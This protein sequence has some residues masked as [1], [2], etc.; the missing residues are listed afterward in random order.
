MEITPQIYLGEHR[1]L[2]QVINAFIHVRHGIHH[3]LGQ[4]MQ[5]PIV[6]TH[7]L[8]TIV[9]FGKQHSRPKRRLGGLNPPKRQILVELPS[10]LHLFLGAGAENTVAGWDR[11]QNE[12]DP[13]VGGPKGWQARGNFLGENAPKPI[14]RL[15]DYGRNEFL[16]DAWG[17]AGGDRKFSPIARQK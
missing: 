7:P 8:G 11:I 5:P 9:L 6:H 2:P 3:L 16:N 15:L 1:G 10:K 4:I 14:S 13:M 12:V 17:F